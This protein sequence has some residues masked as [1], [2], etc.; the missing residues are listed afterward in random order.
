VLLD[1]RENFKREI[2]LDASDVTFLFLLAE[3][4]YLKRLAS[5]VLKVS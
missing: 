5:E 3:D 2:R 4:G 1:C